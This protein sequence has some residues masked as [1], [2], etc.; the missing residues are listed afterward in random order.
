M[1]HFYTLT[2]RYQKEKLR[3][4]FYLQFCIKMNKSN[5]GGERPGYGKPWWWF[6][7]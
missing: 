6:S 5:Q 4:Q 2:T 1:L 7:H 3:K